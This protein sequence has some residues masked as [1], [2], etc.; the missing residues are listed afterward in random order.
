LPLM[1]VKHSINRQIIY[2][3]KQSNFSV[4]KLYS[5]A[6]WEKYSSICLLKNSGEYFEKGTHALQSTMWSGTRGY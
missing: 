1:L 2:K 5:S 6:K 4:N 3:V